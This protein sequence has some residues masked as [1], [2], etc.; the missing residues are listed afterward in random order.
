MSHS[1]T[2]ERRVRYAL[3]KLADFFVTR[4]SQI[5]RLSR[6]FFRIKLARLLR[7]FPYHS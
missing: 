5:Y 2:A 4:I 3:K 1:T 6:G 7:S